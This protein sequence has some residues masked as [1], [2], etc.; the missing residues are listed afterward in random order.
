MSGRARGFTL[1]EILLVLVLGAMLIGLVVPLGVTQVDRARAQSEWLTLER[2]IRGLAMQ[3]FIRSDYLTLRA[4]GRELSWR[5]G[6][7]DRGA[8][9]F[10]QLRFSPEQTITINP[11]G[12]ADTSSLEVLQRERRRRLDI[13]P[14]DDA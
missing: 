8:L 5:S 13:R 3:A 4:A 2:E 12:I 14:D 6:R 7:G 10:E 1:V 9:T 11:N